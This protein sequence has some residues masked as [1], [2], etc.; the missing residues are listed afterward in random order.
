MDKDLLTQTI[1]AVCMIA[2]LIVVPGGTMLWAVTGAL[3]LS[4]AVAI[5]LGS[6]FSAGL[7][8]VLMVA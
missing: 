4:H 1:L 7:F 3:P 5:M 6:M 8:A 2:L